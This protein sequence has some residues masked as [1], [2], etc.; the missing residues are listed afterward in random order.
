MGSSASLVSPVTQSTQ[1]IDEVNDKVGHLISIKSAGMLLKPGLRTPSRSRG[2][3][4]SFETGI[5]SVDSSNT[6]LSARS[7]HRSRSCDEYDTGLCKSYEDN[8][9]VNKNRALLRRANGERYLNIASMSDSL[10]VDIQREPEQDKPVIKNSK[11]LLVRA[12]TLSND[13][14]IDES[15]QKFS[16]ALMWIKTK[17]YAT[18]EMN[19]QVN[20]QSLRQ[21]K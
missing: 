10:L 11:K 16:Q 14:I 7:P 21:A 9:L 12:R 4:E 2:R 18:E 8:I 1:K 13:E 5:T 17:N 20:Q 15:K 19:D 6:L 3:T